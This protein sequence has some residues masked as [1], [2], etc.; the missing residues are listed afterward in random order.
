MTLQA[1]SVI[2]VFDKITMFI[3]ILHIAS[4]YFLIS[5]RPRHTGAYLRGTG[6]AGNDLIIKEVN[7]WIIAGPQRGHLSAQITSFNTNLVHLT[8]NMSSNATRCPQN[9]L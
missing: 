9:L 5:K 2:I 7:E 4:A 1:A 8:A 3:N 6:V